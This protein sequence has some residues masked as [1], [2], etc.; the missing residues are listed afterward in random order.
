[1]A[2]ADTASI[3]KII[4][5]KIDS[6]NITNHTQK[7][8]SEYGLK[9]S[10]IKNGNCQ[11]GIDIS[12]EDDKSCIA[13][14]MKV[15]MSMEHEGNK[16]ELFSTEAVYTYRI[17]KF[18]SLFVMNEPGKYTIPDGFMRTLMGT[19][20]GGMRGIM[21][22]STTIAEY[23]KIILPL[24]ETSKLLEEVKKAQSEMKLSTNPSSKKS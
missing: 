2:K 7:H 13:I 6:I 5:Y 19:A 17:K 20:L 11:I 12:I 9:S 23:K 21:V 4:E 18:K 16:Y 8:F 24:I 1:M 14:P 15:V 10:D 22:A 3:N